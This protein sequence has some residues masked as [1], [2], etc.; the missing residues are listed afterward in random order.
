MVPHF[1][2]Y[3]ILQP[4]ILFLQSVIIITTQKTRQA[5]NVKDGPRD[6]SP[7]TFLHMS[8]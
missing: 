4:E 5:N 7:P 8:L 2:N 1:V 3:S 6:R